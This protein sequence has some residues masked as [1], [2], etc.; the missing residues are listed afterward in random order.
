ML[1]A[2]ISD[3]LG[4]QMFAY[5]AVKTI[6]QKKGY[7]FRFIRA[8][9]TRINSSDPKYGSELHTIFPQTSS[10]LLDE[11]PPLPNTWNESITPSSS[12]IYT[13][14]ATEV[15][16]NTYM[17]GHFISCLYF[18]DNLDQVRKWFAFSPDIL[19]ACQSR[20]KRVQEAYP[21]RQ[22]VAVHFRVGDDYLKQG[23]LLHE[24][25]WFHAA[26]YMIQ[27]Y[28]K[29]HLLFLPFYDH[30]PSSG[31]LVNR[32]MQR[33]PCENIRGTLVEDMCTLTL[34]R[35]LIVCNSSFSAMAGILNHMPGKQVLRPSVYPSGTQYQPADCFPGTW[36]VIPARQNR[37]SF[38]YCGFMK[39]KGRLLKVLRS[40]FPC[41]RS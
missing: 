8:H 34:V 16:D 28:G 32:F 4:N 1:V 7:E 22:P 37:F 6:A 12:Q 35:N 31:G 41:K 9:N 33:Y 23:F 17:K 19:E 18:M 30:R 36:T 3:Q 11:L 40:A 2:D 5:A 13:E 39:T 25:Y 21:G 14:E 10:E 24:S 26:E 15:P 20:L 29:E 38:L 27:K